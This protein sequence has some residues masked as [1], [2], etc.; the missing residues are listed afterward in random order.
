MLLDFS[1][2]R[3]SVFAV[4]GQQLMVSH[5]LSNLSTIPTLTHYIPATVGSLLTS[6][7]PC[8]GL[9]SDYSFDLQALLE[10]RFP[11]LYS[12]FKFSAHSV[13]MALLNETK[14]TPYS[15]HPQSPL[16]HS[17]FSFSMTLISINFIILLFILIVYISLIL[18]GKLLE[19]RNFHLFFTDISQ[20]YR[21]VPASE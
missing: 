17:H 7:T 11:S 5:H 6:N 3:S 1:Q 20:V 14:Q 18:E 9:C 12:N 21:T 8:Q 10:D 16:L 19:Y 15:C 2:R 4:V 13:Q